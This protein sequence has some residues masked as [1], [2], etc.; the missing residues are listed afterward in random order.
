MV[1]GET[2]DVLNRFHQTGFI[3]GEEVQNGLEPGLWILELGQAKVI[4]DIDDLLTDGF[5]VEVSRT[6]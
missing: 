1:I 4:K 2:R 5:L 3:T 6:E